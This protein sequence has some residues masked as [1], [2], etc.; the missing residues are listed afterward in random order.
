DRFLGTL[1]EPGIDFVTDGVAPVLPDKFAV[2]FAETHQHRGIFFHRR[3]TR[4]FVVGPDPDVPV[5]HDWRTETQVAQAGDPFN[6]LTPT[7]QGLP[8]W[9]HFDHPRHR[10]IL[11]RADCIARL[12]TAEHGPVGSRS[13]ADDENSRDNERR[14]QRELWRW[15]AGSFHDKDVGGVGLLVLQRAR[16][17]EAS[18]AC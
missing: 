11:L 6:V 3:I 13:G 5:G 1:Y 9:I 17:S 12:V 7:R 15:R 16:C 2:T 14:M 8:L 4:L 10:W 18:M